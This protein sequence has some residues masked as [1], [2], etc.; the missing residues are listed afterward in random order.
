MEM[1]DPGALSHVGY[2]HAGSETVA[3]APTSGLLAPGEKRKR[4]EMRVPLSGLL[5]ESVQPHS[6]PSGQNS[7]V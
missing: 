6:Y 7:V 5:P 1:S 2:L 4:M 3:L